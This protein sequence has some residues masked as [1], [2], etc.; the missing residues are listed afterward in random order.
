[1]RKI[2][3]GDFPMVLDSRADNF[4]ESVIYSVLEGTEV[5]DLYY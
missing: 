1:M 2:M 3:F 4:L 5:V